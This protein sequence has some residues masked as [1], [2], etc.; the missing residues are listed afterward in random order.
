MANLAPSN[1]LVNSPDNRFV[2]LN[3]NLANYPLARDPRAKARWFRSKRTDAWCADLP[4]DERIRL[5]LPDDVDRSLRHL[6]TAFDMNVLA[7]LSSEASRL[8]RDQISLQQNQFL[9]RLGLSAASGSN[10][11]RLESSLD[12]WATITIK[13][14]KWYQRQ[15]RDTLYLDPPVED[16]SITRTAFA[17]RISEQWW[18]LL[19]RSYFEIIPL[20]LP[21]DAATQNLVLMVLVSKTSKNQIGPYN[22]SFTR[23]LAR[24]Y[25]KIGLG[26]RNRRQRLHNAVEMAVDWFASNG[27]EFA[28]RRVGEADSA[29][30]MIT[31]PDISKTIRGP[32]DVE[33]MDNEE[34][35]AYY[36]KQNKRKSAR[37]DEWQAPE[38]EDDDEYDRRSSE[39]SD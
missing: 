21:L 5:I 10:R 29:S 24:F 2:R 25:G 6:P 39:Y 31:K 30:F 4:G 16:I 32:E 27:G 11:R 9:E 26:H 1:R 8:K 33:E 7:L 12:Y 17:V 15:Q 36:R 38:E 19:N 20:P 22:I 28:R 34:R 18:T 35:D 14:D 23:Q 3:K 13:F 37:R